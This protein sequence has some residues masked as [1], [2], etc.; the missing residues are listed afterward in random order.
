[1]LIESKDKKGNITLKV[2][3]HK[4]DNSKRNV[5]IASRYDVYKEAQVFALN[6]SHNLKQ[7]NILYG[8]GLGYHIKELLKFLDS[9]QKLM[10]E[11]FFIPLSIRIKIQELSC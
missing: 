9:N 5:Y 1:M 4:V 11:T 2:E 7:T 3:V 8:I 10:I 6:H